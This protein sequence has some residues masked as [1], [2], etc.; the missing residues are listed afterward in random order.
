M[1]DAAGSIGDEAK[2]GTDKAK[3]GLAG[4]VE[5]LEEAIPLAEQLKGILQEIVTLGSQADI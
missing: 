5:G 1:A 4:M 3:A 2:K